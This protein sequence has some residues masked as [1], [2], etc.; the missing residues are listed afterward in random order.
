M[1]CYIK[2]VHIKNNK[3]FFEIALS[4]F[5]WLDSQ[6]IILGENSAHQDAGA[7][8][9]VLIWNL[10]SSS[11]KINILLWFYRW[12]QSL[13]ASCVLYDFNMPCFINIPL[14][15]FQLYWLKQEMTATV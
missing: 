15:I 14:G 8:K 5:G 10:L 2:T 6:S 12:Y 3:P 13:E 1:K 7:A 9:I 11:A 4:F